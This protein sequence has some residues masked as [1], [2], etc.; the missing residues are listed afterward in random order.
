MLPLLRYAIERF[1]E[2]I[3]LRYLKGLA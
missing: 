1:P 3:R 2:E